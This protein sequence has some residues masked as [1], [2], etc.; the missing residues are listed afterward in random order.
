MCVHEKG[1]KSK[2]GGGGENKK[3]IK[4]SKPAQTKQNTVSRVQTSEVLLRADSNPKQIYQ[5]KWA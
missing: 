5:R 3:K 2:K 1:E 4:K